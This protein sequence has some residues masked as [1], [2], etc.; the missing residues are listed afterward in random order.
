LSLAALSVG[1]ET[2]LNFGTVNLSLTGD[3]NYSN[4]INLIATQ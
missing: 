2:N 1:G 3:F 4:T